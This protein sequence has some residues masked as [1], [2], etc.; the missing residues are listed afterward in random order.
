MFDVF[1]AYATDEK[2]ENEGVRKELG[3]GA[4][5]VIAR[6]YNPLFNKLLLAALETHKV[7]LDSLP[8]DERVKLDNKL[9]CE[10]M[11]ESILLDFKVNFKGK[12]MAYSK[13]NAFTLL[14]IKD[15]RL[16]VVEEANKIDN[17]RVAADE[18]DSKN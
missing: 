9:L 13:E 15:F 6:A 7:T 11:A 16:K 8:D 14:S 2:K 5:M 10:V 1:K 18:A 12:P 3:G 4:Y 17:Y